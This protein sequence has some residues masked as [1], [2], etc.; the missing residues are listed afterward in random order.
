[1]KLD[2][3]GFV[4]VFGACFPGKIRF[5]CASAFA[6]ASARQVAEI[7]WVRLGSFWVRF[8]AKSSFLGE[9]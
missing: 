2:L 3:F 8:F 7:N 6:E 4:F 9:K 1:M 5:R